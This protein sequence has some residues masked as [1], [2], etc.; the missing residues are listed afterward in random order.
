MGICL[1]RYRKNS[2]YRKINFIQEEI[3]NVFKKVFFTFFVNIFYVLLLLAFTQAA[4]PAEYIEL[5][6]EG[7]FEDPELIN[8]RPGW[9]VVRGR[10]ELEV[11]RKARTGSY[12]V[13]FTA[14]PERGH[15]SMFGLNLGGAAFT[16]GVEVQPGASYHASV[17][18]KGKG[19]ASIIV[20][21]W[22]TV[23]LGAET[24][25]DT[26]PVELTDEW[27]PV[28][29]IYSPTDRR[30]KRATFMIQLE[31]KNAE[32]LF[33]DASFRFKPAANPGISLEEEVPSLQFSLTLETRDTEAEIYLNG[34]LIETSGGTADIT[35]EEG[36]HVLGITC[37]AR[38]EFP[39]VRITSPDFPE[40]GKRWRFHPGRSVPEEW[41]SVEFNDSDWLPAEKGPDGYIQMMGDSG[42]THFRQVLIWNETHHTGPQRWLIPP[43]PEWGFPV[44]GL[45]ALRIALYS[46]LPFAL[47]DSQFI[48]EIPDGFRLLPVDEHGLR[49]IFNI[50]AETA[51]EELF[52]KDGRLW[53][54]YNMNYS[55]THLRP[56][57]GHYTVW[58]VMMK[59]DLPIGAYFEFRIR[60]LARKNITELPQ[61]I[62]VKI[63]PPVEGRMPDQFRIGAYAGLGFWNSLISDKLMDE[64]AKQA[65]KAG[66]NQFTIRP[67]RWGEEWERQLRRLHDTVRAQGARV[68]LFPSFNYP[69][70]GAWVGG[71][72]GE[73]GRVYQWALSKK[74][75]RARYFEAS[76][77]WTPEE[78]ESTHLC[79]IFIKNNADD[80]RSALREDYRVMMEEFTPEASGLFINFERRAW[81]RTRGGSPGGAGSYCFC[82]LCKEEFRIAADITEFEALTDRTILS[83]YYEEWDHFWN[84]N[85]ADILAIAGEAARKLGL[86]Y[87]LYTWA[88]NRNLWEG[89]AGTLDI[90]FAGNPGDR[91][92]EGEIQ[93]RMDT[94]GDYY[95]EEI[96]AP[97]RIGQRF[98]YHYLR[99]PDR[100]FPPSGDVK[101][102]S[103]SGFFEPRSWKNQVL[104]VAAAMGGGIDLQNP[105]DFPGGA[106]YYI[107]EASRIISVYENF[108]LHGKR[109]DDDV[110][111]DELKPSDRLLLEYE[112][113][114]LFLLFN[115]TAKSKSVSV[116]FSNLP[117]NFEII[118]FE[119]DKIF[120][121]K[122]EITVT[123]PPLDTV[124]LHL[125]K[126]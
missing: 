56:D 105:L 70:L 28:R 88:G 17:W 125:K 4:K 44:G 114:K 46:P 106:L 2:D 10:G 122:R 89:A 126:T 96:R 98:A 82:E 90:L 92:A 38:G 110:Y 103:H 108:F 36:I 23:N 30:V 39:G 102:L 60:R 21:Q 26:P 123:I 107:G 16:H 101:V 58:P 67:N 121:N 37:L 75:A 104:R 80:F 85:Q 63:L 42:E 77:E 20:N 15:N 48:L 95:R 83:K 81:H 5:M 12:A 52:E 100:N 61:S 87:M 86:E 117:Q 74:G 57:R 49:Y 119:T 34:E 71:H 18:A 65:A 69:F 19:R 84:Q 112:D 79:P 55:R 99:G 11:V 6:P 66:F 118:P 45:E 41:H 35:I 91:P 76:R 54:R 7:S 59:E 27:Q 40:I 3:V 43:M 24:F 62:P 14:K 50:P 13:K 53:R 124:V 25:Q 1:L 9:E 68:I 47:E 78:R 116:K 64:A 113:E 120:K 93:D 109:K 29:V 51:I 115:G 22:S 111:S 73:D 97:L 72:V 94:F 33:D 32:A 31:G 8:S